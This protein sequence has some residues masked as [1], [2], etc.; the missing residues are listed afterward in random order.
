MQT[1]TAISPA[2]AAATERPASRSSLTEDG[3]LGGRLR[4][5]QPEKGFRA[6]IDSV[7]LAATVPC[8][9]GETLFEAG[10]GTGVASLCIAA[11]VKDIHITGVEVSGRY[12]M[13]GE[14]NIANNGFE[15]NINIITGDVKEALRRD[16]ADW[17]EHGSYSHAFANPPFFDD[18]KIT[19]SPISLKATAHG[20]GPDD[21]ELWV[22]VLG[23]MVTMRGT[24]TFVHRADSL[25]RL[26]TAMEGRF[27]DIRVAPLH[28]REGMAATRIIVQGV[29]GTKGPMQLLPGLILHTSG[30]QFT[31]EADAILRDGMAWR[32]R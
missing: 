31:P 29:K 30:A 6:G 2:P 22:K 11:R 20:F 12:A 16:L 1:N 24:V 10:I 3:F 5:L 25:G 14:K 26:L 28:A 23:T 8:G 32:L 7:F 18:N 27:G 19:K 9:P 17:P 21:L 4:I 15:S 13:I